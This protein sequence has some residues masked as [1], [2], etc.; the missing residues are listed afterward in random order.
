[1][2]KQVVAAVNSKQDEDAD[3]N[4]S[5]YNQN[6][7][8]TLSANETAA[9]WEDADGGPAYYLILKTSSGSQVKVQLL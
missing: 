5:Y 2:Y 9:F 8:P 7:E 6:D 1:M 4:I 3:L